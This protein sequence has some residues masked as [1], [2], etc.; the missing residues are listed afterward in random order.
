MVG[1][2]EMVVMIRVHESPFSPSEMGGL[3]V[4]STGDC[5]CLR[6][7]AQITYI[8]TTE[9]SSEIQGKMARRTAEAEKL[10]P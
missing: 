8:R 10:A 5:L 1:K 3:E 4:V 7:A 9:E 6:A 2:F